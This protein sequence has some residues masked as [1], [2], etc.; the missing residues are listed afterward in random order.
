[1]RE[2]KHAR[3]KLNSAAI[4]QLMS[5]TTS[6]IGEKHMGNT[7]TQGEAVYQAVLITVGE[8]RGKV[9]DYITDAQKKE[10]HDAVYRM[11]KDGVTVHARNPPDEELRKYIPGLVNNWMRKDLRLNGGSPY[12]T[13]N[14]GIRAGSGDEQLRNLK[15]LLTKV[16][17]DSEATAAVKAAIEERQA[18][19]K[20]AAKTINVAVLPE[21][22]RHLVQQ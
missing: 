6:R 5:A 13:K 15:L 4:K 21:K 2:Q 3:L 20:P 7:I 17:G 11:F 9:L 19:I 18:Q 8:P 14:P 12:V 16:S 22:L 1:M 10:V